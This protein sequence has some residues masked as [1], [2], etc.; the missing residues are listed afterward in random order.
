MPKVET[1]LS[2]LEN[3][4]SE[5]KAKVDAVMSSAVIAHVVTKYKVQLETESHRILLKCLRLPPD[6][7]VCSTFMKIITEFDNTVLR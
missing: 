4:I 5:A 3:E 2:I 7:Q 6:N 1:N